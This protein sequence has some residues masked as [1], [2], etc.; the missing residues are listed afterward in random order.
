[1]NTLYYKR[2]DCRL[3]GS[4][5]VAIVLPLEPM[6]IATPNFRVLDA[7]ADSM[8][9]TDAVPMDLFLCRDCGHLQILHVGNPDIQYTNYVYTT[10]LSLGLREH[11]SQYAREVIERIRPRV[12]SLVVELGSND[13]TFLHFF[14]VDHGMAVLGLDPAR[15]IARQATLSGIETIED[16]FDPEIA[17]Q[18][19]ETK[20]P[21]KIVVANNVIANIDN[22]ADWM[23][24]VRELLASDGVFVFE[25][26]Y[27]LDVIT[28]NLLDTVYHEHL[29]YFNVK[30]LD[31]FFA[32]LGMEMIDVQRIWTKGGSIRV[33]AQ[34]AG[35]ALPR[36]AAVSAFAADEIAQGAY[37]PDLY[38]RL[39]DDI[40]TIRRDLKTII[41]EQ[42]KAGKAVAGYGVS[43]GTVTLLPQFQ[44]TR[45]IAFLVD[46]DPKKDPILVGPGYSIP[47]LPPKAIYERNPGAV[48]VFA[49]R[50]IDP[51][52]HKN[53]EYLQR[54]G[55]FV[56][57]LPKVSV[58]G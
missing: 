13:G 4:Q 29:S 17:R 37:E 28:K 52:A 47:V 41:A 7:S 25:T 45:D 46:D 21:A 44:L 10:S 12:G 56:L 20:G 39:G 1:M 53:K 2:D 18:I 58:V 31:A 50:Y 16:F 11:F 24:G 55:K 5:N 42:R 19:R 27:G 3:C 33:T 51:I 22:I 8:V 9:F 6:P 49:W 36:S 54:G 30:P 26:Q 57:P 35:G 40:G 38:R 14:K 43:V 48:I 23:T 32:G 34:L 15:E